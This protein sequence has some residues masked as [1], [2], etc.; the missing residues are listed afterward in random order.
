MG[1]SD[2]TGQRGALNGNLPRTSGRR[3]HWWR[4][5]LASVVVLVVA[6]VFVSVQ[7]LPGPA[8]P[9]LTLSPSNATAEGAGGSSIDGTWNVGKGSLAGYRVPEQFLWQHDTLVAR[10]DMVTG[11]FVIAHAEVSSAALRVDLSTV[12]ANGKTPSGLAG[13][14]DTTSHRDATFALTTPIVL[15]SE[16]AI[17]KTFTS[18][19]TGLLAIRGTTRSVTFAVTARYD[20]SQLEATGSI[21]ITFS[22]WKIKA[23]FAVQQ[24]GIAEFL[25]VMHQ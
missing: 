3:H 4:W 8:T 16:P 6:G 2:K 20:G 23:P 1:M 25:L 14:L 24:Q 19:A 22:D 18:S 9:S 11:K 5:I 21:P 7:S 12:K 17:N 15:G 13:I 10:T